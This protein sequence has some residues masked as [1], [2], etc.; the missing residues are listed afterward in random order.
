MPS[1]KK[2]TLRKTVFRDVE[3][4]MVENNAGKSRGVERKSRKREGRRGSKRREGRKG[5]RGEE[6]DEL[7]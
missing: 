3:V 7:E 6:G 2:R 4:L 1:E 5:T